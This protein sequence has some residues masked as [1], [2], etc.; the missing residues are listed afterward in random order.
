[1]AMAAVQGVLRTAT[2]TG[3]A[4]AALAVVLLTGCG[5]ASSERDVTATVERFQAALTAGDGSA[6]CAELTAATRSAVE[7]AEHAPCARAVLAM[8]L[9]STGTVTGSDVYL[10][11]AIARIGPNATF[12][13]Q[14]ADGWR[15]SAA[16]CTPTAPDRPYDCEL[17]S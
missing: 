1:M 9:P 11:S 2:R 4:G 7:S 12:L 14:T 15:I 13:D 6:A 3:A 5:A 16:G 17:E 8:D 10:T